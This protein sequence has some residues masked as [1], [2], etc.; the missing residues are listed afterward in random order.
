MD[1]TRSRPPVGM[2]GFLLKTKRLQDLRERNGDRESCQSHG[3]LE[4]TT[5]PTNV[6]VAGFAHLFY[7]SIFTFSYGMT[8]P[9]KNLALFES[10]N[11]YGRGCVQKIKIHSPT[12]HLIQS[13]FLGKPNGMIS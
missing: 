5:K 3:V 6:D 11:C 7:S 2:L 8:T 1:F 10:Q 13:S 4:L 12:R 9:G